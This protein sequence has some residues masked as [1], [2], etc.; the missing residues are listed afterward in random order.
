MGLSSPIYAGMQPGDN[1]L[2][3]VQYPGAPKG[4]AA[5]TGVNPRESFV[6]LYAEAPSMGITSITPERVWQCA[7]SGQC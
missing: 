3:A 1:P 6:N 4:R 5:I 2:G 7:I